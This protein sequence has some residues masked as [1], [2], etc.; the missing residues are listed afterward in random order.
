MKSDHRRA[1][2]PS[3]H[4][5]PFRGIADRLSSAHP[6]SQLAAVTVPIIL[7]LTVAALAF[8]WRGY[9]RSIETADRESQLLAAS[10]ANDAER[11]LANRVETLSALTA[12]VVLQS[13]NLDQMY[14]Y[15]TRVV[16]LTGFSEVGLV[17]LSGYAQTVGGTEPLRTPL[18]IGDREHVIRALRTGEPAIGGVQISRVSG[19]P[20]VSIVVPVKVGNRMTALI[21][22]AVRLNGPKST[23]LRFGDVEGLRVVDGR[24]NLAVV[25]KEGLRELRSVTSWP[26]YSTARGTDSGVLRAQS[27]VLGEPDRVVGFASVRGS[28][29]VVLVDRPQAEVY[30]AARSMLQTEIGLSAIFAAVSLLFVAWAAI[31]LDAG[32]ERFVLFID[33]LTHDVGTPLTVIRAYA[34][35]LQRRLREDSAAVSSVTEIERAGR[36]IERMV[37]GLADLL[38]PDGR[39]ELDRTEVDLVRLVR[40]MVTE[41]EMRTGRVIR[42]EPAQGSMLG[43]WDGLRIERL[44]DNLLSNAIKYSGSDTEVVVDLSIQHHL[45][46]RDAILQVRDHGIGV[47]VGEQRSI[48]GR[49]RRGS[50]T[51]GVP[52]K[53]VGLASVRQI[54]QEHD[55]TVDLVSTPGQG[56]TVT[57][58]LPWPEDEAGTDDEATE[59]EAAAE[60]SVALPPGSGSSGSP[61]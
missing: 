25:G 57:V 7:L 43:E 31:R 13:G 60:S 5:H 11:F 18:Y 41:Y 35:R 16:Q 14:E 40:E 9:Q 21:A 3:R 10:A 54:A 28:D 56:T 36:R 44:V 30:G 51:S 26:G 55:G 53:G 6:G 23:D 33:T 61:A 47:P 52:G 8:A 29:W 49:F 20:T 17:D 1:A 46:S 37:Q 32:A 24:G 27:G 19:E 15:F 45:G 22:G 58:R 2:P 59:D 42:Y 50:N 39:S 4:R 12:A 38:D 34:T 48:W